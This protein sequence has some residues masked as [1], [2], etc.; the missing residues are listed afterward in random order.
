MRIGTKKRP[1]RPALK[2]GISQRTSLSGEPVFGFFIYTI[3]FFA[4]A[5]GDT[6]RALA[7]MYSSA[8]PEL[9]IEKIIF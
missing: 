2:R 7:S 5:A 4:G 8:V 3:G 9:K 6:A 1:M